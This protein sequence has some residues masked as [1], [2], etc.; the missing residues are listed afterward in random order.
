MNNDQRGLFAAAGIAALAVGGAALAVGVAAATGP[1]RETRPAAAPSSAAPAETGYGTAPYVGGPWHLAQVERAGARWAVPA[2]LD[3]T[4]E[5][6]AAGDVR[7]FDSVNTVFGR[8]TTTPTGFV[9][10]RSGSTLAAY[11][12]SD[13]ARRAVIAGVDAIAFGE[14]G[15]RSPPSVPSQADLAGGRLVI[16]VAGFTLTFARG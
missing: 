7:L 10:A 9:T 6:T 8:Y 12:G 1:S 16:R 14:P 15:H 13:D 5:F 4:I 2:D 3:A 11:D